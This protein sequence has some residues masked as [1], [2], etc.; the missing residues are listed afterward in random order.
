MN[1]ELAKLLEAYNAYFDARGADAI[2]LHEIF[3]SRLDDV[4]DKHPGLSRANL[5][6]AVKLR[7]KKMRWVKS[8]QPPTLPP[9]A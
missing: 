7:A 1:P 8:Q 3:Q 9:S 5:E 2:K 6:Q 4:L